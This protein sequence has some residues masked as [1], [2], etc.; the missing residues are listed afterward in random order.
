MSYPGT[1]I[2]TGPRQN[3]V[4]AFGLAHTPRPW[5]WHSAVTVCTEC[6][7]HGTVR[8][9][10]QPTVSDPYPET[11]C[12]CG[13]GEHE[14]ECAVCGYNLP[15]TGFDCLACETVALLSDSELGR[16]NPDAFAEAIVQ[17][18]EVRRAS[19]RRAA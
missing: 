5:N 3:P 19:M 18:V 11:A 6:N 13:L 1:D 8:S 9:H 2:Y 17:A 14:P 4:R 15:I 16:F 12:D 7:G 10:R